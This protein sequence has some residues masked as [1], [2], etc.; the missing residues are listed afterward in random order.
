M[1]MIFMNFQL[2]AGIVQVLA[3]LL[4]DFHGI[5]LRYLFFAPIYLLLTWVVNP[6][7]IL[8]TFSKAVKAV[9]GKGKGTWKSP[10]R[11]EGMNG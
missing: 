11:K 7:T 5:K 3:A 10:E 9:M 4:M 6:L 8:F 1:S 2:L